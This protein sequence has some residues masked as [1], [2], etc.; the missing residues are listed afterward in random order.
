MRQLLAE[1]FMPN[2]VRM[3]TAS[4]L[5]KQLGI[6]WRLG[7]AHFAEHL[8]DGDLASNAGNWQWVAGTGANPRPNTIFNPERQAKRFDPTGEYV[9]RWTG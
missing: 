5:T 4:Y 8:L 3:V 2:R 9:A 1:G 7:A 6:D